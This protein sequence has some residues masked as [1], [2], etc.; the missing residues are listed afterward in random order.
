M[1]RGWFE[2]ARAAKYPTIEAAARALGVSPRLI[3][4]LEGGSVTAPEIAK[5]IGKG[6][7]LTPDQVV[8]I[9]CQD[10]VIRRRAE[11]ALKPDERIIMA[12]Y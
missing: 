12:Q 6:L 4:W 7:G 2:T 8:A 9:T 10:S 11:K 1:E 5:R 3:E